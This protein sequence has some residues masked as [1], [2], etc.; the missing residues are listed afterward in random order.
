MSLQDKILAQDG[1]PDQ[2]AQA[3]DEFGIAFKKG[4]LG[5]HG[6]G[7]RPVLLVA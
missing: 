2:R 3:P 7:R 1:Q 5:E 6:D 4:D